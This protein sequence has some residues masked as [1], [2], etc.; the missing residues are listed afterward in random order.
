MPELNVNDSICTRC[1]LCAKVCPTGI[2][3]IPDGQTPRYVGDGVGRCISCGHCEAVCPVGALTLFD[4]QLTLVRYG[5]VNAEVDPERLSAYLRMRRSVRNYRDTPVERTLI[6]RLMDLVRY[7]PSSSNS[8]TVRWLIIYNTAELRRLTGLA[9]DWM[10]SVAAS[11]API[12]TYFDFADIIQAWDHGDDPVCRH[13]PHLVVAYSHKDT[14]AARTDA[15]IAL[16]HLD[17]IAPSL[18]LG[19]CWGGFFQMAASQW[20]PLQEALDLP[21]D[22]VSIYAMM[23]GFPQF[24]YQRTP[25]RNPLTVTWRY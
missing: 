4:T 9:V 8:Q 21:V 2:V 24:P 14:I 20:Q 15:I 13:A 18:G 10:R 1:G 25:K 3:R 19:S 6:D 5:Q 23:L 11:D 7:A 22:H 17:I 16:S 12:T